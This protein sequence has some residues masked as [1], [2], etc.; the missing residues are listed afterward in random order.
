MNAKKDPKNKS[1]QKTAPVK[2]QP[3]SSKKIVGKSDVV[4]TPSENPFDKNYLISE[5]CQSNHF[6][7]LKTSPTVKCAGDFPRIF[8][9][10]EALEKMRILVGHSQK[11]IGWLSSVQ[12][13]GN[14]YIIDDLFIISQQVDTTTCE[15]TEEGLC[16][17]AQEIAELENGADLWNSIK[18]WGHSHVNMGT[19]PSSQD[20]TQFK[21]FAK[22]NDWFIMLIANKG[23]DI[24][25]DMVDNVRGIEF[26]N[27]SWQP[28]VQTPA[29]DAKAIV[30]QMLAKVK[31]LPART[32]SS[33]A[34]DYCYS[35]SPRIYY[36][37]AYDD[38]GTVTTREIMRQMSKLDKNESLIDEESLIDDFEPAPM[39][40]L[41]AGSKNFDKISKIEEM[42]DSMTFDGLTIDDCIELSETPAM[43][44]EEF[45]SEVFI[46]E[47]AAS[48]CTKS[49]KLKLWR[50]CRDC[51]EELIQ[52]SDYICSGG[53]VSEIIN[54]K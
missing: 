43:D 10:P 8:I 27:L 39:S 15:I 2:K 6:F 41:F 14:D 30:D 38:N 13:R 17:F 49:E 45:F 29:I 25:L 16:N 21:F 1:L 4:S 40:E 23:G 44:V 31:A 26:N 36:P 19:S 32:Y 3:K 33:G 52:Y 18:V 9:T 46:S 50:L 12:R 28:Y 22:D 47:L 54:Q 11:E 51:G 53:D 42:I 7:P 34:Y 37:D 5:K 20:Q 35:N 24:H 48:R